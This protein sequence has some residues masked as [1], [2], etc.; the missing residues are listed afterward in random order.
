[1]C[2]Y[3]TDGSRPVSLAFLDNDNNANY[4]F[5]RDANTEPR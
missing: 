2:R 5:Y 1:M 4:T 3:A